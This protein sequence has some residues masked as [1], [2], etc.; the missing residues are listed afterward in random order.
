[1][2]DRLQRSRFVAQVVASVERSIWDS[3]NA[4]A[5]QLQTL[6]EQG[7]L[8]YWLLN[9]ADFV[10]SQWEYCESLPQNQREKLK[11][12]SSALPPGISTSLLRMTDLLEASQTD[13]WALRLRVDILEY[14]QNF[15]HQ[16]LNEQK[17]SL[18]TPIKPCLRESASPTSSRIVLSRTYLSRFQELLLAILCKTWP[19]RWTEP[20]LRNDVD[21]ELRE[22]LQFTH[23]GDNHG[24]LEHCIRI[25]LPN[26]L[27]QSLLEHFSKILE[28]GNKLVKSVPSVIFTANLHVGSDSFL[29]WAT[30]KRLEGSKI[31]CS[32]HGGLNGQGIVPTRGEEFEQSFPDQ[33][34]HWGW[35]DSDRSTKI[36]A[37]L[38]VWSTRRRQRKTQNELLMITD[39]TFRNSRKSWSSVEDDR[40][41]REMLLDTY[42]KIPSHVQKLTTVRLHHDHDKYDISHRDMWESIHPSARL[43]VGMDSIAPLQKR[44]RLVMCTTLGTS[45]IVQ[46]GKSIPT[47]LRLHPEVHAVR[48]SCKELFLTME[49]QKLVHYSSDSV[50]T[51]LEE[52]WDRLDT[53]WLSDGVQRLRTDYLNK[54]GYV[55]RRPLREM[56]DALVELRSSGRK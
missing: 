42:S 14:W 20:E 32:Q 27:P 56:R 34:F 2:V 26:Y 51:F 44:A 10:A 7:A 16:D 19:L 5:P 54:F 18:S 35:S 47:I 43:N 6:T 39:C 24:C 23:Q 36:P 13:Q 4:S 40:M 15:G 46:F 55:S 1:M 25:L 38:L 50:H 48:D 33:F 21:H 28:F 29:I 12:D 45:E 3:Q 17:T 30:Y 31:V 52:F 22:N 8:R 49:E 11:F 9:F 37:Q 53:W 41:Y